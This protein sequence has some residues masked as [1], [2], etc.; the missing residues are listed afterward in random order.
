[1]TCAIRGCGQP[2]VSTI[3]A[4]TTRDPRCFDHEREAVD[5][6]GYTACLP[7]PVSPWLGSVAEAVSALRGHPA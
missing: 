3:V 6:D 5:R 4:G 2:A 1:M 7:R